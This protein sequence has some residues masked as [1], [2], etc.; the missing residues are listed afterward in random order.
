MLYID[1]YKKDDP[2]FKRLVGVNRATFV[3]MAAES[4]RLEPPSTHKVKGQKRGHKSKL[5]YKDKVL[6]L[7]MYY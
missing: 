3:Q 6:M 7:L 2:T 4:I 5:S 1:L